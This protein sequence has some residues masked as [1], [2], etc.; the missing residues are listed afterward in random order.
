MDA[1][2]LAAAYRL[3]V[4]QPLTTNERFVIAAGS[5]TD[6]ELVGF[7]KTGDVSLLHDT[8]PINID[9][10]K[11]QRVLDWKPR[12]K[13]ETFVDMLNYIKAQE[14]NFGISGISE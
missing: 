1:R 10:S 13:R 4:E 14:Q 3:V 5:H 7:A 9:S 12:S 6:A 11:V 8:P 2:D